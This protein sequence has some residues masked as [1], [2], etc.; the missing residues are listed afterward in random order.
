MS[1][2][3]IRRRKCGLSTSDPVARLMPRVEP[4]RLIESGRED[5]PARREPAA[6]KQDPI[7]NILSYR[8]GQKKSLTRFAAS[9]NKNMSATL[10]DQLRII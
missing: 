2:P 7:Q 10:L 8:H 6:N 4:G 3:E 5:Q 1:R 9:S